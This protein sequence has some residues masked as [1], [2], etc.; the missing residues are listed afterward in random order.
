MPSLCPTSLPAPCTPHAALLPIP[1]KGM[2][3]HAPFCCQALALLLHPANTCRL[4]NSRATS[5]RKP[6]HS[7]E[8]LSEWW[9]ILIVH[10]SFSRCP[11]Q[12][13]QSLPVQQGHADPS[14]AKATSPLWASV[15]QFIA[16]T[17]CT[18]GIQAVPDP[19]LREQDEQKG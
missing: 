11:R 17:C 15:F 3:L 16:D 7:S 19:G 1:R 9:T 8:C 6:P 4:Q 13:A 10:L 2:S 14:G 18:A 12:T 5:S